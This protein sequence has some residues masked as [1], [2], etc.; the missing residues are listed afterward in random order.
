VLYLAE[1]ATFSADLGKMAPGKE[2][3]AKLS[4]AWVDPRSADRVPI[5]ALP[6]AGLRSFSTPE[7]WEDALLILEAGGGEGG[8]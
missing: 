5:G 1:G 2:A 7:G 4:G 8:P 3:G 6:A